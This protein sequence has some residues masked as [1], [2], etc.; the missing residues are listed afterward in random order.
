MIPCES[1][2]QVMSTVAY[3]KLMCMFA[4]DSD[5]LLL[6]TFANG[7]EFFFF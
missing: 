3:V 7:I 2:F 6:E 1:L 4:R 5:V